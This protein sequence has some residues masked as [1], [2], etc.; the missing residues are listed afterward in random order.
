M[1]ERIF[2]ISEME[3]KFIALCEELS[4]SFKIPITNRAVNMISITRRRAG[5]VKRAILAKHLPKS[6]SK[7]LKDMIQTYKLKQTL[8]NA[9]LLDNYVLHGYPELDKK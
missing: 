5:I 8:N 7:H 3:N 9:E 2:S 4:N 6:R 1:Q